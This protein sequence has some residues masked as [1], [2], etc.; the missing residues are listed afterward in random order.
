MRSAAEDVA[1]TVSTIVLIATATLPWAHEQRLLFSSRDDVSGFG[2]PTGALVAL[3]VLS[4]VLLTADLLVQRF[5]KVTAVD[6][7]SKKA[8]PIVRVVLGSIT[9]ATVAFGYL[10]VMD[11]ATSAVL[12]ALAAAAVVAYHG[13]LAFWD[14]TTQ[15]AS[16]D[17]RQA[18]D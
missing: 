18:D 14:G 13:Y 9:L 15:D 16:A 12:I 10:R 4:A 7:I 1:L 6:S 3:G 11:A 8:T 2:G 17:E 5:M